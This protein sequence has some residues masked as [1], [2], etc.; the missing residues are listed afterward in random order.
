MFFFSYFN[1]LLGEFIWFVFVLKR[2]EYPIRPLVLLSF[3][4]K[5]TGDTLAISVYLFAGSWFCSL[6]CLVLPLQDLAFVA[7]Y[8][9]RAHRATP[10]SD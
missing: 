7:V 4:S 6:M 5:L 10:G 3:L 1:T 9:Y 2:E 8:L